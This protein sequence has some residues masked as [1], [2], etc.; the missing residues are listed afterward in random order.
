MDSIRIGLPT[1]SQ[2]S[3]V[4]NPK[5]F[6]TYVKEKQR[7]RKLGIELSLDANARPLAWG[8]AME[9]YV[10]NTFLDTSYTLESKNT[11][12]HPS[13]IWCGT[14]DVKKKDLVGDIKCPFT[15]VSFCDLVE[16][17]DLGSIEVFRKDEPDYYWQLVSNAILCKVNFAELIVWY[18][19]ASEMTAILEH[20]SN[21][22]DFELQ[23]GV[24]WINYDHDRKQTPYMPDSSKYK[25]INRFVFEVPKE[26]KE[27]LEKQMR[28]AYEKITA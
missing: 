9:S 4:I 18:P 7:E 2:A 11:D 22:D 10:F 8:N 16:I 13:G 15:R 25:N 12:L 6:D 5:K 14:K 23:K 1:S 24:D 26:D 21:I 3:R 28:L 27:M 20:I 19:Y 17:I